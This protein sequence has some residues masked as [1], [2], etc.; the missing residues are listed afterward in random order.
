MALFNMS[1]LVLLSYYLGIE[2]IQCPGCIL[3]RQ[4][5]YAG[6][7]LEMAG[8]G[9]CNSAADHAA[10]SEAQKGGCWRARG[11]DP[12]P[13]AWWTVCATSPTQGLA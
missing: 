13:Q 8:M 12:L 6:K 10:A 2:V 11:R 4:A 3:I 7:R 9:D 1:N 5:A